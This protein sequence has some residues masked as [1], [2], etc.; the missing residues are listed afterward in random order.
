VFLPQALGADEFLR[1]TWHESDRVVVFSHWQGETCVAATP[2]LVADTADLTALLVD[3]LGD[4]V[5][6]PIPA[7]APRARTLRE[8]LLNIVRRRRN[9]QPGVVVAT[10]LWRRSA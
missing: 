3:A 1:V 6:R 9:D 5:R 7:V 4:A 2:V 10:R 8:R